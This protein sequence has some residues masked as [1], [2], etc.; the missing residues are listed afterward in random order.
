QTPD[1]SDEFKD[2]KIFKSLLKHLVTF[3]EK[4]ADQIQLLVIN[5]DYTDVIE[6][7]NIIVKFDGIGTKGNKYGLIDDIIT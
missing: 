3:S 4:Y 7:S 1:D 6:D 5:N 2:S